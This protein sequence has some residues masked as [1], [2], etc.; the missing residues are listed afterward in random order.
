MEYLAFERRLL[1]LMFR[2]NV[3]LT[4]VHIAYHLGIAIAEARAHLDTM[5]EAGIL[6]LDSD[7]A[8]HLVYSYPLRPDPSLLPDP[9]H[10]RR[11]RKTPRPGTVSLVP[12]ESPT[13]A[14]QS[15]S[16]PPASAGQLAELDLLDELEPRYSPVAAAAL[17]F[18][19]PGVGQIYSGRVPQGIGWMLATGLGYLFFLVPGLILH[20]CCVVNAAAV[21]KGLPALADG[22]N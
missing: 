22:I 14:T 15:S 21:P 18:F 20:I 8:G 10:P 2:T 6:E 16:G 9:P 11:R 5:V 4:P 19:L 1:R 17:S 7:E 13:L 3:L 12:T